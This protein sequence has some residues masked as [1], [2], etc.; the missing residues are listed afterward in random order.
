MAFEMLKYHAPD[1]SLEKFVNAPDAILLP[2]LKDGVA[3]ENY[4]S[5]SMYP[6]YVK[7]NGKW[8]LP[9]ES[10][11]DSSIVYDKARNHLD[12]VE[13]RNIKKGDL[14][15]TGRTENCENGIYMHCHGFEEEGEALA[16]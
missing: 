5:T 7:I 1:F 10:R 16:D 14:V 11:M 15:V 6:E 13:N 3:P 4:H 12:V 2:S 9:E 8:L